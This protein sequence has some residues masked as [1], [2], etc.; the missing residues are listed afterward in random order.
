MSVLAKFIRNTPLRGLQSYFNAQG[1]DL[2]EAVNGSGEEADIV[3]PLLVAVDDLTDEQRAKI[4]VDSERITEMTDEV[5]QTALLSVVSERDHLESLENAYDRS[6]WVFLNEPAAF[7]RAE[8]V[9]YTDHYRQGRMWD[10]F[11][12]PEGVVVSTH[13]DHHD[14]LKERIRDYF[15][16]DNAKVEVYQRT[17]PNFDEPD[18][19]LVQIMV[20]RE[21][22]PDSYLEFQGEDLARRHRRP[23]YEAVL[24]Y[25]ADSGVIE[26][27]AQGRECRA[28]LARMFSETLLRREIEAEHVPLRRFDLSRLLRPHDFPTEPEDAIETVDLVLL[29]LQPYDGEGERYTIEVNRKTNATIHEVA[30]RRFGD[31]DPLAGSNRVTRA[32][33]SIRFFPDADSRR[34]K[35]LPVT[36]TMPNG[37]DLKGK[38]E[39]ERLIGE[40]YLARWGLV[41]EI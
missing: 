22:L 13:P 40:K 12:G 15:R 35:V 29:R 4:A 37:C 32:K 23:V 31:T 8:E 21:G 7:R 20:Y 38:T 30:R 33:L 39:K 5:G 28:D 27:V 34:G 25:E 17:R 18:S 6:L 41:E 16:T 3:K 9:R 2:P 1:I 14:D 11:L 26:V 10:G 36:I 19:N 24:T